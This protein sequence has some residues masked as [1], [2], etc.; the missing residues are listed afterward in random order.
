MVTKKLILIDAVNWSDQYPREHPLRNVGGWFTRWL[1]GTGRFETEVLAPNANG[2]IALPDRVDAVIMSGSPRDAWN[3]DP[4]NFKFG[5][6][7]LECER[8]SLPFLGVCYGHQLLGRMFGGKVARD[9]NGLELG[10]F[11]VQLTPEG[12]A[13]P[14]FKGMSDSIQVLQSHQDAV[15]SL[16][17]GARL[18]GFGTQTHIQSISLRDHLFGVQFHPEADPDVF[19]FLWSPRRLAWREKAA[20]DFDERLATM[21]PTPLAPRVLTNFTDH[22]LT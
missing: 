17:P 21:Q 12:Q 5:E 16:P 4:M 14:I 1:D 22:F 18:L 7:I 13:A 3:D 19:R 8:R 9:P 15:L 6:L 20:F 10:N 2:E 11:A